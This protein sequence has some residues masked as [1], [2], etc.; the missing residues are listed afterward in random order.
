[1]NNPYWLAQKV[2]AFSGFNFLLK[3]SGGGSESH[4]E[5]ASWTAECALTQ[6]QTLKPAV[7]LQICW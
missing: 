5:V 3:T 2:M 1:M 4:S 7:H 6:S